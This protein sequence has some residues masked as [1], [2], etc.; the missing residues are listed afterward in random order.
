MTDQYVSEGIRLYRY[1]GPAD[2]LRGTVAQAGGTRIATIADLD[3][4][5]R[6]TVP[7]P[8][9]TGLFA[10]TFVIDAAGNLR[11]AARH[12]EHVA[13]A[14]ARPV[15]S[16]GEM[17]FL[18]R[19]AEWEVAELS[20]QSTGYCPEPESWPHVRRA[21]TS[22]PLAHPGGFTYACLFRRC[23]RCD[24]LNIIKDM[25]YECG[26]C[27]APLPTRWNI[28]ATTPSTR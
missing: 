11:L 7:A 17:F 1:V 24:Q 23:P 18:R 25:L 13:C 8:G 9:A 16:A 5:V 26:A 2:L 19:G 27:G 28:D 22:I 10:A 4:W 21:L 20:N 14:E 12:S 6:E 3:A 15:R